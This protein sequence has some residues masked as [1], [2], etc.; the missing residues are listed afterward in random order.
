MNSVIDDI[1]SIKLIMKKEKLEEIK[2]VIADEWKFKFYSILMGLLEKTKNQ[3][4]IMKVIMKESELKPQGKTIGQIVGKILK[5]VGKFSKITLSPS[6]ELSFF[7]DIR[8]IIEKKFA[9]PVNITF[10][11]DSKELKKAAQSLPGRP[12]LIIS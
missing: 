6:E 1:N 12:A 2:I 9:C 10:E 5:N 11:R 4:E 8:P 3:G 7:E